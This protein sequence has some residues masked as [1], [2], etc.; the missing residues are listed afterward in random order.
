MA[1][2]RTL[3]LGGVRSGKSAHGEA[4]L[5]AYPQVRYI[6]T[7]PTISTDTE[8]VA[9]VRAHRERRGEHYLTV[10]TSDVAAAL[11]GDPDTP[12]LVDDI[13]NWV[14]AHVD[15]VDGWDHPE[16]GIADA[17]AALHDAVAGYT[18]DLVL[19]SPEVGLAP[20]PP[21]PA[22][23][24]FQ[25]DLGSVNAL[26]AQVCDRVLLVVAGRVLELPAGEPVDI[27]AAQPVPITPAPVPVEAATPTE[28]VAPVMDT[29]PGPGAIPAAD[30]AD[31]VV[32][33]GALPVPA[34]PVDPAD[35]EIF[36]PIDAPDHDVAEAARARQLTLTKPPGSL[37]RLEEL[38]NWVAACQG[39]CPPRPLRSPR[40]VVFAGDHGVARDGV[41]AYPPEVTAQMVANIGGGGAA[42]NVLARRA[43]ATVHV[44]DISVDADT[45]PAV[46][47]FKVRRSCGDLRV[48]DTLTIDEARQALAAGRAIADSLV[49]AGADLLIAGE[50]GIGNTTPASVLIGTITSREPVEVVGRGSGIDDAGWIRK[51]A[52]IRD[53]MRRVRPHRHDPLTM[54]A[55]VAGA[56]LAAMAGFLAQ[57]AVRRTP[58]IVDGVIVTATALVAEQLA[59]GAVQ[60]W[61]AGHRSVE[62]AHAAALE[63]LDLEPI[64]EMSMRLGEGTGAVLALPVVQSAIDVLTSMATFGEAG[65]SG[66]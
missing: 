8:W 11:T 33:V 19:I 27:T 55:T 1:G 16:R 24:R 64:M 47:A 14:A 2:T 48:T 66:G 44:A 28:A 46:A 37:G 43:G 49:D 32:R 52:A 18:G 17:A 4:L 29:P 23:R 25:D 45:D 53:G 15:A 63:H 7:G 56:D 58:V 13:G 6:A 22:G 38:G 9:R 10:E 60:W 54:L 35:A 61:V 31:A 21:T 40:V 62:P 26:L 36:P 50:M 65:V 3:I 20:V 39:I 34:R 51:T 5:A 59:P 42:I 41:S 30:D 12:T 57:A